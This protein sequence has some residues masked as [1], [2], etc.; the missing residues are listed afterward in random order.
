[1]LSSG[2]YNIIYPIQTFLD[3]LQTFIDRSCKEVLELH[4]LAD[5]SIIKSLALSSTTLPTSVLC[6]TIKRRGGGGGGEVDGGGGWGW[7]SDPLGEPKKTSRFIKG[8]K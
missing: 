7:E 3:R 2:L 5:K 6:R 1:M 4:V 8:H